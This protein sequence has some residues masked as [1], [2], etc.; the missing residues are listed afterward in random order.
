MPQAQRRCATFDGK[1]PP[2]KKPPQRVMPVSQVNGAAL[3]PIAG[4]PAPTGIAIPVGAGLP[5]M[6]C[7]AAPLR[8]LTGTTRRG[9]LFSDRAGPV[10]LGLVDRLFRVPGVQQRAD[11]D[12]GQFA[13]AFEPGFNGCTLFFADRAAFDRA[14]QA[15]IVTAYIV[16]AIGVHGFCQE[17]VEESI[18]CLVVQ[19][20]LEFQVQ[21]EAQFLKLVD[22][23]LLAQTTGAVCG[24]ETILLGNNAAQ[25][26]S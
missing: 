4:K 10:S 6:G 22:T 23:Q 25:S 17:R 11:L 21:L 18:D 16:Q 2:I 8:N 12:L 7:V 19:I 5:A 9:G 20:F 15:E 26:T 3:R 14:H 13:T 1:A 24:H